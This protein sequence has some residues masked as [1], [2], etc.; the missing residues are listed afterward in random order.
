MKKNNDFNCILC[1]H[2]NK[3]SCFDA[4]FSDEWNCPTLTNI[5][6]GKLIKYFPFSAFDKIKDKIEYKR[7]EKYYSEFNE[8]KTEN[9]DIKFIWGIKS[10]YDLSDSKPNLFTMNDFEILYFKGENKYA[11]SVETMISFD[12]NSDEKEYLEN[13]LNRFTKWMVDNGYDINSTLNPYGDMYSMFTEGYN[14]NT[15]FDTIE[16]A[17]RV[18]NILVKGY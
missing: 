4:I 11:I 6:Y 15:H 17:Y 8:D 16:D 18:F 2:R 10:Y 3:N 13:I 5:Y 12:D 9:N 7:T 14:I 1:K